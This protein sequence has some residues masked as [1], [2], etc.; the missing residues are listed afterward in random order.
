M[1]FRGYLM[2]NSK[3]HI[4]PHQFI[5]LGSYDSLPNSREEIDAYR[6]DYTRDLTRIT[7]KGTK[8]SITFNTLDGLDLNEKYLVQQFFAEAMTDTLQRRFHME[9]WNDEDNKYDEGDFYVA[10]VHYPIKEIRTDTIIYAS[11]QYE[12]VEY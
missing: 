8:S 6:D 7:A 10:D 5:E 11:V 2:K 3:G 12:L 9:Y 1:N 4:F